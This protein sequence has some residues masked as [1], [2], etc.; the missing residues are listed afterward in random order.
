MAYKEAR[1]TKYWLKLLKE[2][3]YISA[4]Y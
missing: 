4:F 2:T 1:E 3:G